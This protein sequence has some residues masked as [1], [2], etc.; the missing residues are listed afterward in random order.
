MTELEI[1]QAIAE[2]QLRRN[3]I[4]SDIESL[5]NNQNKADRDISRLKAELAEAKKPKLRHGD[6]RTFGISKEIG[7]IDLS[8]SQHHVIWRNGDKRNCASADESEL[9]GTLYEVFDDLKAI[10]EPLEEFSM[11]WFNFKWDEDGKLSLDCGSYI[12]PDDIAEFILNL[13]RMEA[14]MKRNESNAKS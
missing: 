13:R 12:D 10:Q 3:A 4:T 8:E 2:A 14:T 11:G 6:I 7:I 1:V 5:T 9:I